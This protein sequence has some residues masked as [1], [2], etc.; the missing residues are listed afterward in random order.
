MFWVTEVNTNVVISFLKSY[1]SSQL[2]VRGITSSVEVKEFGATRDAM[3]QVM[4]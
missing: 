3:R 1:T 4:C 2:T